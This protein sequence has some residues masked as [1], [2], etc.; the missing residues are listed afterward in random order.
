MPARITDVAGALPCLSRY[1][2]F[3]T[4]EV[5]NARDLTCAALLASAPFLIT[6]L[7]T[8][9]LHVPYTNG[10]FVTLRCEY[11]TMVTVTMTAR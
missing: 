3:S 1:T 11:W 9:L 10:D 2:H 5:V 6:L 7:A 8:L 4:Q